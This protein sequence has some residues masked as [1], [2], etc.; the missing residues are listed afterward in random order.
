[1]DNKTVSITREFYTLM[2]EK[3]IT[4]LS[5]YLHQ[6][7]HFITPLATLNGKEAYIEAAKKFALAF[8]TLTI[9]TI[10]GSENEA[11]MIYDVELPA[12]IGKFRAAAILTFENFLIKELE[13]I[14][15]GRLVEK[16]KEEIFS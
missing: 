5:K 4:S 14:Y 13:L 15:D 16:K 12:P 8:K 6:D 3:K 7:I 11:V 2:S 10:F 9:H 1:M